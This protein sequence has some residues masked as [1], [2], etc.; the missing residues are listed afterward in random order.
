MNVIN[1]VLIFVIVIAVSALIY[2]LYN[3]IN[4]T[5]IDLGDRDDDNVR[6]QEL[7]IEYLSDET[8][9]AFARTLK[10]NIADD[11]LSKDEME[12]KQKR[13]SDLREAQTNASYGSPSAKKIILNYIKDLLLDEKYEIDEKTIHE[14]IYFDDPNAMKPVE[15]FE[16]IL[17]FYMKV[18]EEKAFEHLVK[19]YELDKPIPYIN[20]YMNNAE[21]SRYKLTKE[22]VDFIYKS[23]IIDG[24]SSIGKVTFHFE[25]KLDILAQRVYERYLGF[26][27]VDMLFYCN[28][29]EI[30]CG[31]SGVTADLFNVTSKKK[32]FPY[33]FESIW[34]V[35]SGINIQLECIGFET[36]DELIRVTDNIYKYNA[37]HVLSEMEGRV[38]GTMY[39]GSR[40]VACRP[41]FANSYMFFMRKFDSSPSVRPADL[42][43]DK[44]AAIPICMMKWCIVSARNI[45]LT[46]G[47]GTGKTTTLKS[48]VRFIKTE[49]NIRLQELQAELNLQYAYPD[50]EIVSFQETETI[51]AQEAL[52]LQ[53]KT[54]GTVNIIGEIAEARQASYFIQTSSVASLFGMATHHAKTVKTLIRSFA[55]NLIECGFY[56]DQA[57]AEREVAETINIDCHLKYETGHRFIERITEILPAEEP[58]YPST[59]DE[60]KN[61]TEA[62]KYYMDAREYYRRVTSPKTFDS[63]NLVE[64]REE[65]DEAGNII[66]AYYLV[67]KPS[68]MMLKDMQEKMNANEYAEMLHELNMMQMLSDG[69]ETEEVKEWE[70]MV[71][72]Y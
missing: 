45:L 3:K 46:G 60:N 71:L 41:P 13:I 69:I 1:I 56:S 14:I 50:R 10:Q 27:V 23:A 52:N 59:L 70:K 6:R 4:T 57:S 20:K 8:R 5:E 9:K 18:Y 29:D 22:M 66:H 38:V 33:S 32:N 67:N 37:P 17:Y 68:E 34:I 49:F 42:I 24:E 28:L 63:K 62:D 12:R 19:D 54:N 51:D 65:T 64:N 31:V 61:C 30:D 43:T 15:K 26:S 11:N 16:T 21:E 53:K 25:E 47:Q 35:Y 48:F 44:N 58:P 55:R 36:Q 2:K 40:I 72:S 7:S 39:N